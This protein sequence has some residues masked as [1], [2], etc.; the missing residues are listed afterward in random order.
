MGSL[1]AV[2]MA[3]AVGALLIGRSAS[4]GHRLCRA[5]RGGLGSSNGLAETLVRRCRSPFA[6]S[7]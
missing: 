2:L 5:D 3:F 1:V 6:V 4:I 7:A